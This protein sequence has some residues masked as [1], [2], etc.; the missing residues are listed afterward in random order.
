MAIP[1]AVAILEYAPPVPERPAARLLR[2]VL[3]VFFVAVAFSVIG[4]IFQPVVYQA[5]GILAVNTTAPTVNVGTLAADQANHV[6]GLKAPA[7]LAAAV[8]S[9]SPAGNGATVQPSVLAAGLHVN[10]VPDS[11]LIAVNYSADDPKIAS[12][13]ANAVISTYVA[14]SP[15]LTVVAAPTPPARPSGGKL[16]MVG[17][18]AI[19]L[20]WSMSDGFIP[21]YVPGWGAQWTNT[22]IFSILILVLVFRPSGLF[23]Q[24]TTDKV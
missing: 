11:R 24:A 1:H 18:F 23:G 9:L 6:S 12:A 3:M 10:A 2:Q 16:Y 15:G 21:T 17:G 22:V 7:N 4:Y 20:I 5:T 13:I 19:G 8:A 14:A